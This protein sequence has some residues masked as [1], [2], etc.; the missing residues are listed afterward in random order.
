[1]INLDAGLSVSFIATSLEDLIK[2]KHKRKSNTRSIESFLNQYLC[3]CVPLALQLHFSPQS[4][5]FTPRL[6][7]SPNFQFFFLRSKWNSKF[8]KNPTAPVFFMSVNF[9]AITLPFQFIWKTINQKYEQKLFFWV[10]QGKK[11]KNVSCCINNG[12]HPTRASVVFVIIELIVITSS[13]VRK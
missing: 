7:P 5:V 10:K 2:L 1:M 4:K 6:V 11:P 3:L 13:T 8:Q 12:A 9:S